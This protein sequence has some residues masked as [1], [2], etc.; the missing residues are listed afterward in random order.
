M[1][2]AEVIQIPVPREEANAAKF[3]AGRNMATRII[4]LQ[5]SYDIGDDALIEQALRAAE[6]KVV[7]EIGKE[8]K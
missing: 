4:D 3:Y 1:Y 5:R 8:A 6:A 7:E 2:S